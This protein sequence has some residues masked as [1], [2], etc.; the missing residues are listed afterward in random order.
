MRRRRIDRLDFA[1]LSHC[2][3]EN[4]GL[5]QL[6]ASFPRG[7]VYRHADKLLDSGLLAKQGPIYSTTEQG[8][9]WLANLDRHVDWDVWDDIYPPIRYVPTRQHRAMFELTT[10]GVAARQA[11]VRDDHHAGFLFMGPT[12]AW[13]TSA[14][15]FQSRA[16]GLDPSKTI[17]DLTTETVRSLFVRRDG[18]GHMSFKRDLLDGPLICFDDLLEVQL[19]LRPV[20]HHFLSGRIVLPVENAIL[21]I[22]P[23]PVITLN[24]RDKATL[25]QQTSFTTA[26]LRRFVVVDLS[27][28]RL[29]D[30]ATIGHHALEAAEKHPPLELPLPKF[31]ANA[32]RPHIVALVRDILIPRVWDRVDTEMLTTL[33][34]GMSGFILDPEL[35]IQQ[36][37]YDYATTAET[38][39]WT[40]AGWSDSVGSFS[41]HTPLSGQ[42]NQTSSP[43]QEDHIILWRPAMEGYRE[44]ALPPFGISDRN[45]ARLLAIAG[46]ENIPLEHTDHALDVIL[47][48]WE[49]RQRDG[50]NL[51][52]AYSAIR[53]AKDLGQ[54]SIAIQDIKLAMR[55]RRDIHAGAYTEEELQAALDLVP[56]L[57][58][59][60]LTAHDDRLEPVLEV[61]VK[62]LNSDR[63]LMELDEWLRAQP[64]PCLEGNEPPRYPRLDDNK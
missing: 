10:A 4:A 61:A 3:N 62:V 18:G 37:L 9:C 42:K 14:A 15:I 21:H 30:L 46:Q 24:P 31:D 8:K 20:I 49:Q 55:L 47:D 17:V 32:Y 12:L 33:V 51:D 7:T 38:L 6:L 57:R 39:G 5:S 13:K 11:R 54:R 56:V 36:T 63:S 50:H 60:G 1:I 41:L 23:V 44:S 45:K 26:Q 22:A 48:N 43:P 29:R 59:Q 27:N 53:L 19:S 28:T 40:T 58:D 35:A 34:S 52:E 16:L 25:E 64:D 2:V